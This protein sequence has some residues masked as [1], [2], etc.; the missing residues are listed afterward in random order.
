MDMADTDALTQAYQQDG[1][2]VVRG[3]LSADE[4]KL[5]HEGVASNLAS[6]G[7]LAAVASSSDDP[8]EFFEDFCNFER[9]PEYRA[10]VMRSRMAEVA[11]RLM[12]SSVVRFYHDHL[13]I[14]TAGTRQSTPWHQD[15]PYYN[16]DGRQTCSVWTPLDPVPEAATLKFVAGSHLGP[17]LMPVSFLT[18]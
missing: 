6:P 12:R 13:L 17:W 7:P 10:L 1:S 14:K 18:K 4:L 8:G 11:G 16:I 15:Q 3:L 5:L 9:V 2:V